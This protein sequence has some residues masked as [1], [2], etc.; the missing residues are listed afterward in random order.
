M[1]QRTRVMQ[2]NVRMVLILVDGQSTVGDLSLKTGNSQLTENA[3]RE[4]EKGGFIEPLVEQDSLWAESKRVAQEIRAAAI[5]KAL[6]FSGPKDREGALGLEPSMAERPI[7]MQSIF[8]TPLRSDLPMSQFSLDPTPSGHVSGEPASPLPA[9]VE[10]KVPAWKQTKPSK[11]A[12]PSFVD[13]IMAYLSGSNRKTDEAILIKPIRRGQRR[14]M[15]WTKVVVFGVFFV[16]GLAFLLASFFPYSR[17]LPEVELVI[18]QASGRAA[19][20][21]SMRVDVYPKP[22]LFL[23]DVRLGTGKEELRI[24][25]IRL[26]PAISTLTASKTVFREAVLSGVILPAELIAGLPSIFLAMSMPEARIGIENI[27]FD[28]TDISF[29][30]L[31]FSGMEGE[32]G[33]SAE[34]ALQSLALHSPDRSLNLLAKPLAQSLDVSIEGFGWRPSQTSPYLFDS[35]NVKGSLENGAFSITAMDLRLF[36]GLIQ[37]AA[38]LRADTKPSISGDVMFERISASRLG[39]AIGIGQ[40]FAG[41][42]EGKMRF[43]STAESWATIFSG[44][45]AVGEFTMNRGSI[46]GIDLAEAVRRASGTPVQ[47][48]A[49][50]FEQFSG[51]IK[52]T[53]TSYQFSRLVLSSGL[54]QSTGQ[55]EIDK[56]LM[57]SGRMNLQMR[58]TVNQLRVPVFISGP[59]KTPEV[60][61][62]KG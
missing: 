11:V 48:G 36:D 59:L 33:L 30:G 60:Q 2:R 24:A 53:P 54:M 22:G 44:I 34:G 19:K 57:V 17:Y 45:D 46:R 35:V 38:I 52:L 18:A 23:G 21:G 51:Q 4:L 10:T 27:R 26:Q 32:T 49:T 37:G 42:T 15:N 9:Q 16:L 61:V 25:E 1:H 6:L 8:Q 12:A 29:G 56:E 14:S 3:L 47:G 28:K 40:Q 7:S 50:L 5:D 13:R 41:E 43:S 58:G 62:G 20:V 39:D 31:G 55:I